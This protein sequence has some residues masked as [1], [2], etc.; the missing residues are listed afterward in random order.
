MLLAFLA[1]LAFRAPAASAPAPRWCSSP[2]L[3]AWTL[4]GIRDVLG[5]N[6]IVREQMYFLPA[7]PP[8]SAIVVTD[9][10]VCERA[11]RAYY[12]HRLGPIPAGGVSVIRVGNRYV[13]YG[14]NRAGEW[15]IMSIYSDRFEPI[16]N[17]A[18]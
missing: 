7:L 16:T 12:R 11:A 10:R 18:S 9:E 2:A 3:A 5:R 15:T 4:G 17:L 6:P 14:A 13:V 8:D 1:A